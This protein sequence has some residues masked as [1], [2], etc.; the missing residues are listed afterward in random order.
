MNKHVCSRVRSMRWTVFFDSFRI[1]GKAA[2]FLGEYA[3]AVDHFQTAIGLNGQVLPAW[4][5]LA[6]TQIA[7]GDTEKAIETYQK[8]V[9]LLCGDIPL[10]SHLVGEIWYLSQYCRLLFCTIWFALQGCVFFNLD[11]I[12]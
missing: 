3:G 5:G 4:E 7:L 10:F 11:Q 1:A 8:L 9:S 12:T 6:S 2:Y